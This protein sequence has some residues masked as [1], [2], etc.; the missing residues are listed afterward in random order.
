MPLKFI[1]VIIDTLGS[2]TLVV[3]FGVTALQDLDG[4]I[5]GRAAGGYSEQYFAPSS[6]N[7]G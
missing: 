4:I 5:I 1:F 2:L 6:K 3:R 7:N